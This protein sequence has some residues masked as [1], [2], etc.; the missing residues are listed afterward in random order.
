M[1]RPEPEACGAD[2]FV[3]S[4]MKASKSAEIAADLFSTGSIFGILASFRELEV[5]VMLAMQ[6]SSLLDV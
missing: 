3:I 6:A 5:Q 4:A 2:D 1:R